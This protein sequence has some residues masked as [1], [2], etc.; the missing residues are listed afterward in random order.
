MR[1]HAFAVVVTGL[2]LAAAT[3]VAHAQE[4]SSLQE[5]MTPAEFKAAG[6]D[7]L[8]P[9]ELARLN[10]FVHTDTEKRVSDARGKQDPKRVG[11]R[12]SGANRDPIVSHIPGTFHGWDGGT[13]FHLENGQVW[14]QINSDS[15][16]GGIRMEN[17]EVTIKP[18]LFG[19]WELSVKGYSAVAKVERVQ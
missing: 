9:D 7:K 4:F 17:P 16:L 2:L 18:G 3:V 10:A 14:H 6:L 1:R 15:R 5:R 12:D 19:S 8:S 13:T 11:F